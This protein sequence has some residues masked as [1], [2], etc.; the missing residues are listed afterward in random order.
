MVP[1]LRTARPE[2][3]PEILKLRRAVILAINSCDEPDEESMWLELIGF[4]PEWRD[5]LKRCRAAKV[6]EA[7]QS[8][9][10]ANVFQ[11]LTS[12]RITDAQAS[13]AL[14]QIEARAL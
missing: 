14:R 7:E 11:L 4:L 6:L 2:V 9:E 10:R 13:K 5:N 1:Q 3:S 12:Q 8:V